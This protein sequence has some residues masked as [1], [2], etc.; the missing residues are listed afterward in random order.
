[1]LKRIFNNL[2]SNILKYGDK[3]IPV[4][5]TGTLKHRQLM[6]TISNGIKQELSHTASSNI[7]LRNVRKMLELLGNEMTV[8]QTN[9]IFQVKMALSLK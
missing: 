5:I 9:E 4:E 8:K 7:G 6:L 3:K 2:F 1:M